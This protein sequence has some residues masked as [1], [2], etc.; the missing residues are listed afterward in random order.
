MIILLSPAKTLDYENKPII[1]KMS[2]PLFLKQSE[3]LI[4]ALKRKNTKEIASLMK[5]SDKLAELN[6][7]RYKEWKGAKKITKNSKQALFVFKGDVYQ[8]LD[9]ESMSGENISFAQQHLRILSG[10]YGVLRP[11]DLVEPYRLEMGTKLE[12]EK[13]KNLYEFWSEDLVGS[14]AKDLK[15]I[16]SNLLLNLA[17]NEYFKSVKSIDSV[18]EVVSPEFK[19]KTNGTYKIV[20]F[21]A[22]KARG[23]MARWVVKKGITSKSKLKNFNLGGYVYNPEY[24]SS[25][26]PVFLRG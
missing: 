10:L 15:K 17:S 14:I 22:K 19:D 23:M 12:N 21:Y 7:D 18:A 1:N 2:S 6:C 26:K 11:L 25:Q 16:N 5:L 4:D 13:G 9:V 20:S 3:I 24:S 8:G